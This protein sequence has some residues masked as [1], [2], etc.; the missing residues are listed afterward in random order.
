M[1]MLDALLEGLGRESF[2]DFTRRWERGAPW[3]ALRD[4]ETIANYDRVAD[5]IGPAELQEAALASVERL[6]P[7]ERRRFVS[8][9]QRSA[10]RADVNYPG[11]HDEGLEEPQ[12]LAALLSR[13]HGERRGMIRQLLA[14]NESTPATSGLLSSPVAGAVLAGVAV[15]AVRQFTN[16]VSRKR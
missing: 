15:M 1:G 13:M 6:S 3:D 10:R 16:R 5:E 8:E 2:E 4:E 11:V 7:E 14:A 12:A 9:L